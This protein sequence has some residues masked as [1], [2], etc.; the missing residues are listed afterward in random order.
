MGRGRERGVGGGER[1][2]GGG[3]GR[4]ENELEKGKGGGGSS[5]TAVCDVLEGEKQPERKRAGR[6]TSRAPGLGGFTLAAEGH[7]C[8]GLT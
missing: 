5:F 7:A 2:G 4:E 1:G 6:S 8:T 3:G